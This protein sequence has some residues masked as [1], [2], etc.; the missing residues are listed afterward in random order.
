[1]RPVLRLTV[2]LLLTVLVTA[3]AGAQD[4]TVNTTPEWNEGEEFDG[5]VATNDRLTLELDGLDE[6]WRQNYDNFVRSL[7]LGDD[8]NIYFGVRHN[9]EAVVGSVDTDGNELWTEDVSGSTVRALESHEGELYAGTTNDRVYRMDYSGNIIETYDAP[10]DDVNGISI[11]DDTIITSE[12]DLTTSPNTQ[13]VR[14][15]DI[16]DRSDTVLVSIRDVESGQG[17][18]SI[19]ANE[20]HFY[21][22]SG[23]NL[24]LFDRDGNLVFREESSF[25]DRLMGLE[26][27]PMS[28]RIYTAE[29]DERFVAR[30][31]DGQVIWTVDDYSDDT[32]DARPRSE[33]AIA[34]DGSPIFSS[35]FED[36][37][38]YKLTEDGDII[39]EKENPGSALA[40]DESDG[41]IFIGGNN[42]E[43]PDDDGYVIK[44]QEIYEDG[45]RYNSTLYDT[46]DEQFWHEVEVSGEIPG[47]TAR[48]KVVVTKNP[49]ESDPHTTTESFEIEDDDELFDLNNIEGER[50]RFVVDL[51]KV[52]DTETQLLDYL[53]FRYDD[54]PSVPQITDITRTRFEHE[55]GA[56]IGGTR[57]ESLMQLTVENPGSTEKDLETELEGSNSV[58]TETG[59]SSNSYSLD[60]GENRTF[61]VQFRPEEGDGWLNATTTEQSYGLQSSDNLKVKGRNFDV[62]QRREVPGINGAA[63]ILLLL[64]ATVYYLLL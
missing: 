47:E 64:S 15:I 22:T 63:T 50:M 39:W 14:E 55:Y 38:L 10:E 30:D 35:A 16:S 49:G 41:D 34:D 61:E 51:E 33:P 12:V 59:G 4:I 26:V 52:S 23:E 28:D 36:D 58:F 48:L 5:T 32:T 6:E 56:F 46:G 7:V 54:S 11:S 43:N 62:D 42:A 3:H 17:S 57:F 45:G 29:E 18:S 37:S 2:V 13:T 21:T 1:M 60:P 40:V 19:W 8:G 25:N 44:Y 31:R 24:E 27:D 20:T 9:S 53:I